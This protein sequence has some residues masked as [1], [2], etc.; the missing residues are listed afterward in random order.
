MPV[1]TQT[2]HN[3]KTLHRVFGLCGALLALSMVAAVLQDWA[4]EYRKPQTDAKV[5]RTAF[6]EAA[7]AQAEFDQEQSNFDELTRKLAEAQAALDANEQYLALPKRIIE[8][9]REFEMLDRRLNL[10]TRG[11]IAPTQQAIEWLESLIQTTEGTEEHRERLER[12]RAELARLMQEKIEGENQ[13]AAWTKE[14]EEAKAR[15]RAFEKDR[16]AIQDELTVVAG[17]L[18]KA[19][20]RVSELKPG[21]VGQVATIVRDAPLID[22]LNPEVRVIQQVVPDVMQQLNLMQG[23][24]L[25]RCQSCHINIDNREFE[26]ENMYAFL[27]KEI[28]RKSGQNPQAMGE[29]R[30]VV[31][32][33]FWENVLAR[34]GVDSDRG[35]RIDTG[36]KS[37]RQAATAS[38]NALLKSA[39]GEHE[40][41]AAYVGQGGEAGAST[42]RDESDLRRLMGLAQSLR[43]ADW[44]NW[45]AP[46]TDYAASLREMVQ[47]MANKNENRAIDDNYRRALTAQYNETVA[48]EEGKKP[49]SADRVLLAHPRLDLYAH[50]D[51]KHPLTVMGCTSCHDGSGEETQFAHTAHTPS[52]IWVDADTGGLVSPFL[53]LREGSEKDVD[54]YLRELGSM[55]RFSEPEASVVLASNDAAE[56]EPAHA[57]AEES[58]TGAGHGGG[59]AAHGEG[60]H[61]EHHYRTIHDDHYYS[62]P[63]KVADPFGPRAHGHAEAAAWIDPATNKSRRA[64]KQEHFWI[65][66]YNWEHIHYHYWEFPMHELR[67]VES[68]CIRCHTEVADIEHD[69]PKLFKGRTLFASLGCV[70][71]HAVDQLGSYL[72]GQPG[73]ADIRQVGPSLV[74]LREKLSP[75]MAASWIYAPKAFRPTTR[76]P[77]FFLTEN[78]SSPIDIRRTRAETAAMTYYLF[79]AEV[80]ANRPAYN[81]ETP[82]AEVKG[83]VRRGRELFKGVGCLGCH[84]NVNESGLEWVTLDLQERFGL[85]RDEAIARIAAD[86]KAVAEMPDPAQAVE[87]NVGFFEVDGSG[88]TT[89]RIRP[90]QYTRLHW[91][92]KAYQSQR[93]TAYGPELSGVGTKLLAGRTNAEATSWL[94]DWLRHP[95]HYS[96]YT[97]MPSLRLTEQE[98]MDLSAYLLTQKHPSYEPDSFEIDEPM[99]EAIYVN[100]Q[101]NAISEARARQEITSM[102]PEA[103]M[104]EV[105]KRVIQHYGCFSCHQ[106]PGIDSALAGSANVTAFGIKDPHKLDFGYFHPAYDT[107]RPSKADVWLPRAYGVEPDAVKIRE[108]SVGERGVERHSVAWET[109]HEDRRSYLENK[110]HNTR[111]FDRNKVGWDGQM[112]DDGRIIWTDRRDREKRLVEVDGK[113]V[114]A[115]TGADSGLAQ[116]QV[117]ILDLGQPYLKS[118]M[119]NFFV[120]ADQAEAITTYVTGLRPALVRANLQETTRELGALRAEGRYAA[121]AFNCMGCHNAQNNVPTIE[122]YYVVR[123]KQGE[124]S[125]SQTIENLVNAPP[126]LVGNGAKTQHEWFYNFLS[127][128]QMLRPWLQV[129]MPSFN[130]ETDS[131]QRLVEWIAGDSDAQSRHIAAKL[132]EPAGM[133]LDHYHEAYRSAFDEARAAGQKEAQADTIAKAAAS[134]AIGGQLMRPA[135]QS[136]REGVMRMAAE[137][138]LAPPNQLPARGMPREELAGKLGASFSD[139]TF[140][141]DVYKAVDYPFIQPPVRS[142]TELEFYRGEK[143]VTTLGCTKCHVVGDNQ[144]LET[145][146]GILQAA[147]AADQPPAEDEADPYGDAEEDPYGDSA[148][149]EDPYGEES[150]DEDPYGESTDEGDPYGEGDAAPAEPRAPSIKDVQTAPNLLLTRA[151]L[152][153]DYVE[154]WLQKPTAIM[155]GTKMP[156]LFGPDGNVSAFANF[157]DDMRV[158]YEAMFGRTAAEQQQLLRDWLVAA[159]DRRYTMWPITE[160]TFTYTVGDEFVLARDEESRK[161]AVDAR[162]ALIKSWD[163]QLEAQAAET[164]QR[165]FEEAAKAAEAAGKP[166]PTKDV[167]APEPVIGGNA[168]GVPEATKPRP[169]PKGMM[170]PEAAEADREAKV[171]AALTSS[172]PNGRIVGLTL[173]EGTYRPR[174]ESAGDTNTDCKGAHDAA[175]TR[176]MKQD[177]V[178]NANGTLA[179]VVVYL[180][181]APEGASTGGPGKEIDQVACVYE[182]HVVTLTVGEKLLL[183]NTDPFA[184]NLKLTPNN[185]PGFNESQP[186]AGMVKEVVFNNAEMEMML[187]C[188]VHAWMGAYIHVFDHPWHAVSDGDGVFIID[189][190]PAGEYEVSVLHER[191]GEQKFNVTV[192]AGRTTRHDLTFAGG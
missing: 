142:M 58:T 143:L 6:S 134:S 9:Q 117:I 127:N 10:Y 68:S 72:R 115:L 46:V 42:V 164:A 132:G 75:E 47:S 97:T 139:L 81:P 172:G 51:S 86:G 124:I 66:R 181:K 128:V 130:L 154:H 156:H 54:D 67:F 119:P 7:L 151:R 162:K 78:N 171:A 99:L 41:K 120:T 93:Y 131:T 64:V 1:T 173:F 24:V 14:I 108:D 192:E 106:I 102:S 15:I 36:L 83:D 26:A 40:I 55:T 87:S 2:F 168:T 13:Q 109:V 185:N 74:H 159:G 146:Y 65:E 169:Q 82:P 183:K 116:E 4:N 56:G 71:C 161:A 5:W 179:N 38:F 77:H 191:F 138:R 90:D 3:Q 104:M 145:I 39:P 63:S 45:Y 152:Q 91:Y 155:P 84:A 8:L 140:L 141:R 189:D 180:T 12:E 186:V 69:A 126:R 96:D 19:R 121:E 149:Q 59:D 89:G 188:D 95:N 184:H 62:D 111:I 105:G 23:R 174:R 32:V 60:D 157:P 21:I 37:A 80:E 166:L 52:D 107:S 103:K 73:Q 61:G 25:D 177:V 112:S 148:T 176:L 49:L 175:G 123:N 158:K 167:A 182:P 147:A 190:V 136:T 144:K 88:D 43:P 53:V 22:F 125:F 20:T 187:K 110:L 79:H 57:P 70:T 165:W 11:N 137:Y 153:P 48:R 27:E 129:R 85:S 28:A 17:R 33:E 170:E 94:Y 113:F 16:N 44:M 101:I 160:G 92:L 118:K 50:P 133:L 135:Y 98:A 35:A 163:D 29:V 114:D 150:T 34:M 122:Q 100:M 18:D 76:M 30:P 178:V 31:M